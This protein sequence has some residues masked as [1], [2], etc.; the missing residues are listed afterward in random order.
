M[1]VLE[2]LGASKKGPEGP[3]DDQSHH[4]D[5]CVDRPLGFHPLR[6]ATDPGPGGLPPERRL[7]HGPREAEGGPLIADPLLGNHGVEERKEGGHS[8]PRRGLTKYALQAPAEEPPGQDGML[9]WRLA[10]DPPEAVAIRLPT[11]IL[12]QTA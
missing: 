11:V 7:V 6:I 8:P 12:H 2:G 9:P 10:Q 1:K 4:G 5:R 3:L